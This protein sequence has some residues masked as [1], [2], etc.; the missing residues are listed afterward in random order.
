MTAVETTA[1]IDEPGNRRDLRV[2]CHAFDRPLMTAAPNGIWPRPYPPRR[3]REKGPEMPII[4]GPDSD[5]GRLVAEE[6]RRRAQRVVDLGLA[7]PGTDLEETG[8][9]EGDDRWQLATPPRGE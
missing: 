6:F 9:E 5:F 4:G 7:A 1:V 8:A 2:Q 3:A